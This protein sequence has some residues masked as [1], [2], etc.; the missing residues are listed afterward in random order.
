[1]GLMEILAHDLRPRLQCACTKGPGCGRRVISLWPAL[2]QNGVTAPGALLPA[3]VATPGKR[4]SHS[5]C[6]T[7][8][9]QENGSLAARKQGSTER[10]GGEKRKKKE[11]PT[12]T[13]T[14][15][16]KTSRR[17]GDA[18]VL[19][20]QSPK[21]FSFPFPPTGA[22]P[23]PRTCREAW[24]PHSSPAT[25]TATA[26]AH[27]CGIRPA[28]TVAAG[29]AGSLRPST[30]PGQGPKLVSPLPRRDRSPPPCCPPQRAR[31]RRARAPGSA[32]TA[33]PSVTPQLQKATKERRG[34]RNPH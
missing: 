21:Y 6:G 32:A 16:K 20:Q 13:K 34:I 23:S 26:T 9:A 28:P 17:E 29:A 19:C 30:A 15:Q 11:K 10:G 2:A 24:V 22:L 14:K 3:A 1:M 5:T 12:T 27:T 18:Q 8:V 33:G 7:G 25:A 4:C 31:A